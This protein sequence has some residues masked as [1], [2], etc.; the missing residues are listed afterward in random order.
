MTDPEKTRLRDVERAC[1]TLGFEKDHHT[2][3]QTVENAR[4]AVLDAAAD[5]FSEFGL[6]ELSETC[7]R[8]LSEFDGRHLEKPVERW[9][10]VH[11]LHT[12]WKYIDGVYVCNAADPPSV[13]LARPCMNP[14]LATSL[15]EAV[16]A[17][18]LS[19]TGGRVFEW[20]TS[21]GY[22]SDVAEEFATEID[23]TRTAVELCMTPARRERARKSHVALSDREA[24]SR[25][26][27]PSEEWIRPLGEVKR[28]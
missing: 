19:E 23:P 11:H 10:G 25:S 20:A 8:F 4:A 26:Q 3:P 24:H 9:C 21:V 27:D 15:I 1:R 17:H 16:K 12:D 6:T 5:L 18:V 14:P 2:D 7:R 22:F 13:G 28:R